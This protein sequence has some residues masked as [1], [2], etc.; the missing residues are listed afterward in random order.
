MLTIHKGI[1]E[2]LCVE[3][4]G[5]HHLD[6]NALARYEDRKLG[7]RKQHLSGIERRKPLQPSER[8]CNK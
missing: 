8:I 4:A 6:S 1:N 5:L 3:L 7:V 2:R